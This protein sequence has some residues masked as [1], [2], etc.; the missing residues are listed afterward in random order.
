MLAQYTNC[1]DW[2]FWNEAFYKQK[3]HITFKCSISQNRAQNPSNKNSHPMAPLL[4]SWLSLSMTSLTLAS[5]YKLIGEL[6]CLFTSF[7]YCWFAISRINY[8]VGVPKEKRWECTGS[9]CKENKLPVRQSVFCWQWRSES[10]KCNENFKYLETTTFVAAFSQ[11][12]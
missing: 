4:R 11:D 2:K 8:L 6:N 1:S 10:E 7:G 3:I 12:R 9:F 5:E